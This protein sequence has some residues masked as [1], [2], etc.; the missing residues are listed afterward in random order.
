MKLVCR[1]MLSR[2][3]EQQG[4]CVDSTG[5]PAI[6]PPSRAPQ[7]MPGVHVVLA[8]RQEPEQGGLFSNVGLTRSKDTGGIGD[9]QLL[10]QMN[11]D[12]SNSTDFIERA[13]TA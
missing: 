8:G 12:C 6:Q 10:S 2:A 9:I 5:S 4:S 7:A 1:S 13:V 11:I 3:R